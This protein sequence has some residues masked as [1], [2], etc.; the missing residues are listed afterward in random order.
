[1]IRGMRR[2]YVHVT[3]SDLW[4]L[5]QFHQRKLVQSGLAATCV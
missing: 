5:D 4:R 1:M 2:C 3:T